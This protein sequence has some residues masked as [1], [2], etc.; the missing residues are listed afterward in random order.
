MKKLN[1]FIKDESGAV[2]VDWV[3]LTAAIVGIAIAVITVIS[4]GVED[5]SEGIND[6]LQTASAFK[7]SFGGPDSMTFEDYLT[8]ANGGVPLTEENQNDGNIDVLFAALDAAAADSPDGYSFGGGFDPNSGYPVYESY[9]DS[10]VSV[11]GEVY[12]AETYYSENPEI[13]LDLT[14]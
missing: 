6:E 8:A 14:F 5:A 4:S 11:G 9:E 1:N 13:N 3:V 10:T 7:F 2:T 12:D